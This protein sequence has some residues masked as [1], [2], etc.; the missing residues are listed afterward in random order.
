V[1]PARC[2]CAWGGRSRRRECIGHT[3]YFRRDLERRWQCADGLLCCRRL[4]G[5]LLV[6]GTCCRLSI[7][8]W[9]RRKLRRRFETD[10]WMRSWSSIRDG[11]GRCG[12]SDVRQRRFLIDSR[13]LGRDGLTARHLFR[14]RNVGDRR[15][16][17]RFSWRQG[18]HRRRRLRKLNGS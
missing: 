3:R 17:P 16:W 6:R 13:F 5:I 10:L 18:R 1:D 12:L 4:V 15:R 11:S 14:K 8:N 2:R 7:R 9:Q